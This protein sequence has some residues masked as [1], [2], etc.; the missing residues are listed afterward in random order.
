MIFSKDGKLFQAKRGNNHLV[1]PETWHIPGGGI[2]EGE[3]HEQALVREMQEEIGLDLSGYPLELIDDKGTGESEKILESGEKVF[4]K[5]RFFVYKIQLDKNADE[6]NI[7]L[8]PAEYVTYQWTNIEDIKNLKL[9]PPSVELF[10]R[11]GYL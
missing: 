9:T 6:I 4:A 10:T 1:Y 3:T 11:L 8:E 5:M 2:D 7:V